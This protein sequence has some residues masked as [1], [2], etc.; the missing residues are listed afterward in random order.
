SDTPAMVATPT[1]DI[2][3][4]NQLAAALMIDFGQVPE[5]ERN[6]LRLLFTDPRMRT[7]YPEWEDLARAT[8]AYVRM[9]AANQRDDLRL[10]TLVGELSLKDPQFRQ[11]WAGHHVAIKRRGSRNYNHP[12]VGEIILDWDTLTSNADP[13]QQ[14][15]IFT[16]EPGSP[17]EHALRNLGSRSAHPSEHRRP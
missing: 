10:S 7:L 3:A 15:I 12:I 9:E 13:D 2:L 17:S 4:W 14:I 6:F 16:A 5:P 8:T 1:M 11:W